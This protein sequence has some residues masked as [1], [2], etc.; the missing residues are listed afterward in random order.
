MKINRYEDLNLQELDVMK[1]IGSI[2]TGH[3]AT[4][5]SKL[6][7]REVRIT[8]PKVQILDF[9]GAVKRIGKEE[10]I[11]GATLVQM[12]GDLDGLMLFLYDK[13]F[14]RKMLKKLLQT[15]YKDFDAMDDMAFSAL[16]EVGNIIICSYINAFSQLVHVDLHLSV[17]SSTVNMLGGILTVPMA[18]FGYESD[19]LMYSNAD[20][21]MDGKSLPSWLL[22]LPD[23][24]S[25]NTI[26]EKLGV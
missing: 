8:I 6:L 9:D 24:H 12:S 3:A 17:P 1:E 18:E 19:K 16:K 4:A 26:L 23:I 7:Q 20:F 5:L 10:E 21:L 25:L 22:M 14:A 15:E 11:I 13:R 2:G